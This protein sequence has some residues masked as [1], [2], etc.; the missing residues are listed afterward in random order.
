MKPLKSPFYDEC[1]L[2]TNGE[3]INKGRNLAYC[4]LNWMES[5]EDAFHS[6]LHY[7]RDLQTDGYKG[8][9]HDRVAI[10]CLDKGIRTDSDGYK[11]SNDVWTGIERYLV[12]VDPSLKYNPVQGRSSAI[13]L[14]GL[15]PVSY[16]SLE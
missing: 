5:H 1:N 9:L 16:L 10:Y 13:D 7:V 12:L 4:A 3:R 11:F 8:R 6:I 2:T 15:F 14:H